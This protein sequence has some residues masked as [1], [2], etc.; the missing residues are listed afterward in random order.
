[1]VYFEAQNR[2]IQ[3]KNMCYVFIE[4]LFSNLITAKSFRK[5]IHFFI[6]IFPLDSK[7]TTSEMFL[8]VLKG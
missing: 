7:R 2:I 8:K 5:K 3:V 4:I 6:L 1:M